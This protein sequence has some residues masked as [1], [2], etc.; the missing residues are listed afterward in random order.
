MNLVTGYSLKAVKEN[1][2][3]LEELVDRSTAMAVALSY[4]RSQFKNDRP[5]STAFPEHLIP[6]KARAA[7][8]ADNG[9]Q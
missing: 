7:L 4:A 1:I 6:G 5:D 9:E 2:K 3:K 8:E